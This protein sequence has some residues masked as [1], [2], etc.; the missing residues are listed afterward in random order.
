[1]G[2]VKCP[3]HIFSY[4]IGEN[5]R[6]A[7]MRKK[8]TL[9]ELADAVGSSKSYIW[10]LETGNKNPSARLLHKI[11]YALDVPFGYMFARDIDAKE[12]KGVEIS[13]TLPQN[14]PLKLNCLNRADILQAKSK[15]TSQKK[16]CKY[17]K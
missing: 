15:P 17:L 12:L 9:Q 8:A 7:R 11:C 4:N 14:A 2:V 13:V 16:G 5:I 1:M 6:M 3:K 10:E